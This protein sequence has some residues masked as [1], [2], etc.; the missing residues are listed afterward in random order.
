MPC[1]GDHDGPKH[2]R[3]YRSRVFGRREK[4]SMAVSNETLME[5]LFRENACI[6]TFFGPDC[7]AFLHA[8][9]KIGPRAPYNL[10]I[11]TEITKREIAPM[12]EK[13]PDFP[14]IMI[15]V[16]GKP[17]LRGFTRADS[18]SAALCGEKGSVLPYCQP[19]FPDPTLK[20]DFLG[21]AWVSQIPAS[22]FLP[23]LLGIVQLPPPCGG[24]YIGLSFWRGS[25]HLVPNLPY[26]DEFCKRLISCLTLR[27]ESL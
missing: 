25:A 3:Q 14:R 8:A 22:G 11:I 10:R 2:Q 19:V 9:Q 21:P 18:A 27:P 1:S 26:E 15:V 12:A 5:P 13:T 16:N 17:F 4:S 23:I 6:L 24:F 20:R 7:Q